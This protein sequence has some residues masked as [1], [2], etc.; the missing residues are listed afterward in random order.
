M[1]EERKKIL[2]MLA[3]GKITSEEAERL[4]DKLGAT[5]GEPQSNGSA[6]D[7]G[8]TRPPRWLRVVVDSNDGDKVN[9]RV[10]LAL[11]RTGIKLSTLLPSQA[12]EKMRAQGI[13]LSHLGE[14]DGDELLRAIQDLTVD[15]GAST[16]ETVR[17]FCE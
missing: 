3:A 15:V 14:L 8:T 16:G 12:T 9:I 7:S 5:P 2:E 4:L 6:A 10:P 17:I 13:D 1:S 11:V